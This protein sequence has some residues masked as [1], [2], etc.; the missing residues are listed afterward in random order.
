MTRDGDDLT[1]AGCLTWPSYV[2]SGPFP[3]W[4]RLFPRP[5]LSP[6][7]SGFVRSSRSPSPYAERSGRAGERRSERSEGTVEPVRRAV[8]SYARRVN[9]ERRERR[10]RSESET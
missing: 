8:P 6:S 1:T 9:G 5:L 3:S 10:D 4:Q 2:T 7:G